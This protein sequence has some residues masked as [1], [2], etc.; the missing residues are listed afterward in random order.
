MSRTFRRNEDDA[1]HREDNQRKRNARE[2]ARRAKAFADDENWDLAEAN[3]AQ[4]ALVGRQSKGK[5]G[6]FA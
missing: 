6:L 2:W 3:M 5:P 4:A 1:G